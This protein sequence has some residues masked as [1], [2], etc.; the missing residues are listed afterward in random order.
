MAYYSKE[1]IEKAREMD[2]LTYLQQ[3]EPW[4]LVHVS[5][6]TYCTRKHDSLKISN[7]KWMWW[8]QGFG[9]A[10]AL[11]YLVK[12]RGDP[13]TKAMEK[14]LGRETERSPFLMEKSTQEVHA[15][16]GKL[17]LPAKCSTSR[18]VM[19]YL[20][21]RG[22]DREIIKTCIKEGLIYESLPYHN[23]V[24]VGRDAAGEARYASYRA[25][26]PAKIMGEASGSDKKYAFHINGAEDN[27]TLH[28]F[29]SAID[30]LSFAT[31][32]NRR[33]RDWRA[34]SLLSLGGIYAPGASG[35]WKTPSALTYQ[36]QQQEQIKD[37]AL[38][39][40][41]DSAGRAATARLITQLG[42]DYN[43]RDE[44]AIYGKD[45][46]DELQYMIRNRQ[47][48]RKERDEYVR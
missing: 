8:S 17:L 32:M 40:D 11:D 26:N 46:N 19:K 9:G 43:V 15:K 27:Q 36:L 25:C 22:I 18:E 28:V 20:S 44:P 16:A 10:S 37:I 21:A 2:L 31:I 47:R 13:F 38:H 45:I 41:N 34:E 1:Q 4:E 29:E 33:L 24:F 39:L 14:I 6:N 5:G 35:R 3:F 48:I 42:A 7:G 12:V 23:C 30:L